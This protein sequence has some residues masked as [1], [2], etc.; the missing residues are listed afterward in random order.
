MKALNARD[1]S[2]HIVEDDNCLLMSSNEN[3]ESLVFSKNINKKHEASRPYKFAQNWLSKESQALQSSVQVNTDK[4]GDYAPE[5]KEAYDSS[6]YL[7][8]KRKNK[9]NSCSRSKIMPWKTPNTTTGIPE[10]Q[11]NDSMGSH[12]N[13]RKASNT[14]KSYD[15]AKANKNN[16][17]SGKSGTLID[18]WS[19]YLNHDQVSLNNKKYNRELF[20]YFPKI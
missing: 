19:L 17:P 11:T 4:V 15:R 16:V 12:S 14:I 10:Y 2:S 6:M 5:D 13:T 8:S 1:Q 3:E 7:F 20:S 9:S 18:F